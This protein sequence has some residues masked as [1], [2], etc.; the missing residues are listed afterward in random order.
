MRP[1]LLRRTEIFFKQYVVFTFQKAT[2]NGQ[3][4]SDICTLMYCLTPGTRDCD[5]YIPQDGT[6]C[7]NKAVCI[8]LLLRNTF[9]RSYS[10]SLADEYK[11]FIQMT[12]EI[13]SGVLLRFILNQALLSMDILIKCLYDQTETDILIVY[14]TTVEWYASRQ[15]NTL[16]R[17][18]F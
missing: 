6:P 11:F 12:S 3:S 7:G 15:W 4:Y 8:L 18:M 17:I 9:I 13:T 16:Y 14:F 2:F 5:G 10:S 1:S